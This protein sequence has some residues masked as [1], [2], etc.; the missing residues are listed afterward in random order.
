MFVVVMMALGCQISDFSSIDGWDVSSGQWGAG[1]G[2]LNRKIGDESGC[3]GNHD[4]VLKCVIFVV[5]FL[6]FQVFF[7]Y[8]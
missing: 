3:D 4:S 2:C 7:I 1:G 8:I 6:F 5:L